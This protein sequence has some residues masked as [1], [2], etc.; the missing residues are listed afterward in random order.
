MTD[1]Q[2]CN[3]ELLTLYHYAELSEQ[4]ARELEQHLLDCE[5]C[6]ISLDE[7]AAS[8][9]AV[10]HPQLTLS[11]GQ[12]QQF[13]A[14]VSEKIKRPRAYLLQRWGGAFAMA[15]ALGLMVILLRPG[16]QPVVHRPAAA[17][18]ADIEVLEQLEMLKELELLKDLELLQELG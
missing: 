15:A 12:R 4:E 13:S 5:A 9:A 18:L 10:P 6:R 17:A 7:I 16:E 2:N 14:R 3:E 11:E 8:L 1:Q